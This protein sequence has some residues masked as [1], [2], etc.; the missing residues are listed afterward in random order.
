MGTTNPLATLSWK[1]W[2]RPETVE[3]KLC[4]VT[5]Y[6]LTPGK[7][8]QQCKFAI[9]LSFKYGSG[10]W[11]GSGLPKENRATNE[12]KDHMLSC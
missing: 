10:S 12:C 8:S 9:E 3:E 7:K 11:T 2:F 5:N 1:M 4:K 6:Y